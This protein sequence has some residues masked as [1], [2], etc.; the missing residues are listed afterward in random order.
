MEE[1]ATDGGLYC[2]DGTREEVVEEEEEPAVGGESGD[3]E[4]FEGT[5]EPRRVIEDNLSRT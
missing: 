1:L 2:P 4:W 3:R 5:G